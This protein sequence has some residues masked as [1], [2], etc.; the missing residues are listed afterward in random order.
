MKLFAF[1]SIITTLGIALPLAAQPVEE[2]RAVKI[3]NVDSQVLFSDEAIAAAMDF[4]AASG[5]NAVLP[6]VQ[7]AGWTQ[8][9][10]DVME[11][12]FGVRIDP[13][14]A[15]RDPLGVLVREA[16]RVGIEVYPW[17][18]YGFASIYSGGTPPH[19]G[20]II[21]KNP[22]WA[23]LNRS[24]NHCTKNG[25]DW[26]NG[27]HLEVQDF[28][29][30]LAMEIIENYDIDGIEFS[31]R[32]PAMP[33]EC[34]YDDYTKILYRGEHNG[35][36]PPFNFRNPAWRTWRAGKL[37]DFYARVR[38]S[39][40]T[41]DP[42][43]FVA[44]SPSV[45]PWA[46]NE[47]LQD[48]QAWISNGTIDHWIPQFYRQNLAAYQIEVDRA[49]EQAGDRADILVAGILMNVGSYTVPADTLRLFMQSNRDAG[50][51]GEGYFFYEGFK[52]NG[53]ELATFLREEFYSE[54]ALIPGRNGF[55]RRPPAVIRRPESDGSSISGT[56]TATS[57]PG[58]DGPVW[59]FDSQGPG[60]GAIGYK[61]D[62]AEDA[63]YDLYVWTTPGADL[64]DTLQVAVET[65]DAA[66]LNVP[67]AG[68]GWQHAGTIYLTG[69]SD[70]PSVTI[71]SVG[72]DG[73]PAAA[74]AVMAAVNRKLSPGTA[75]SIDK[76]QVAMRQLPSAAS[77]E[78]NYPNPFNP[79]T[80]IV[81]TVN[82]PAQIR[83]TVHDLLG[84]SMA[85]IT[86]GYRST[87]RH[88]VSFNAG[89]HA[90]GMYLV[91]IYSNG[92]AAGSHRMMLVR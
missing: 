62:A 17:F 67:V 26:M 27:I 35:E 56:W 5:I 68:G 24:G 50:I 75:V 34:G 6:V 4:L 25:F 91:R 9:P 43:L 10:S 92:S 13:R 14:L 39:V 61:V 44:S 49:V 81:Y 38:D 28:I 76:E 31:D 36:D 12:G 84:R 46:F 40:K 90:S 89:G 53:D 64:T 30:S 55:Q 45:Y 85:T 22:H 72:T 37:N 59:V 29:I 66:I 11:R 20:H 54:P 82:E 16:R 48:S 15:G 1:L 70:Q 51:R 73:L 71:L 2:L 86:E 7:N 58:F 21:A 42:E 78:M 33:V 47:Y 74:D 32:M 19:G 80:T 52:R 41:R 23:T 60:N 8:Y 87:G 63:W 65:G 83:I 69:D 88:T 79:S 3:T 18:E 57:T 77:I